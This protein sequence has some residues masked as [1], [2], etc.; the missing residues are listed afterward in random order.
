[1]T[2]SLGT[3]R[4]TRVAVIVGSTRP[5]RRG[6]S[7]AD[8]VRGL[9]V[10]RPAVLVGA[11]TVELLDLADYELPLLDE[12]VPAM[13]GGYAHAHTKR[14]AAAISSYDAFVFVS[15]EYNHSVPGALKNAIDF[16]YEEWDGKVAGLVSYG[17]HGGTRA[18]DHLRL[19]L[20]EVRVAAVPTQVAV[21]VM[22]DFDFT[23]F[24]EDDPTAAGVIA[25]RP[26][27]A[28]GLT[29]MLDEIISWSAALQPV[30]VAA[31]GA[32]GLTASA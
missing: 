19:V 2:N 21:S 32:P 29:S 12:A 18:A 24:D 17:V 8:W 9:A 11:A 22:D 30:R 26:T 15:P 27:Q 5:G 3:E 6:A 13:F 31:Q 25:P 23:G 10:Q 16:L 20:A 7:V 14:W 28:A 4:T 1:M